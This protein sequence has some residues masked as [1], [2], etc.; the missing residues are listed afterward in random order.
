MLLLQNISDDG[1]FQGLVVKRIDY[2]HIANKSD[3]SC[4]YT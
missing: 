2:N 1:W 4:S 3:N